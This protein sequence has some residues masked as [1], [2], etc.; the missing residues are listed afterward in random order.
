MQHVNWLS[1][2]EKA[3]F[4]TA[5]EIPME[6]HL[7]LCSHRQK[8]IDQAQSINLYFSG[9]D[10]EEYIAKIHRMAF[11]DEDIL[12]LY[13]IYSMR[14]GEITRSTECESCQ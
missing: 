6:A 12:S 9:N 5:F 7:E 3:V 1:E 4:R 2:H 11:E 10:S 8:Y 14:G 13:Y